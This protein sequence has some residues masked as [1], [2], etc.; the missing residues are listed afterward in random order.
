MFCPNCGKNTSNESRGS[1]CDNERF[2][3]YV[4]EYDD[5]S[6]KELELMETNYSDILESWVCSDCGFEFFKIA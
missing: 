4:D 3:L 5:L 6:G 1:L 2:A